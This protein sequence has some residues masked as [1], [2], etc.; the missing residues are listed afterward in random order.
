MDGAPLKIFTDGSGQDRTASTTAILFEGGEAT[1]VLH[2]QLGSLEHHMTYE[3]KLIGIL[4]GVWI[5]QQTPDACSVSIKA[6]L[7]ATIQVLRAQG[8]KQGLGSYLL[9]K[10][11]ELSTELHER[12]S[13][14]LHLNVSWVSGHDGVAGNEHVDNEAKAAAVG[15]SSAE[16]ELPPLLHSSPLPHSVTAAKQHFHASLMRKW[17]VY[18]QKSHILQSIYP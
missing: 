13:S 12:S 15:S 16:L 10:I 9:D 4:L 6:D 17:K 2:Y 8:H 11:R 14:D 7:Q 3:A 1:K 18:W 5:A